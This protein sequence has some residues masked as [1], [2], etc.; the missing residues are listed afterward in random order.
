VLKIIGRREQK[1]ALE[2]RYSSKDSTW[3]LL[4]PLACDR[5]QLEIVDKVLSKKSS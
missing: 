2:E 3:Y 4:V 1:E 5:R